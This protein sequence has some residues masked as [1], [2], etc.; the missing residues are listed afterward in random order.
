M[1]IVIYGVFRA[2]L[3]VDTKDRLRDGRVQLVRPIWNGMVRQLQEE[4]Y[5]PEV[6]EGKIY[7]RVK[8]KRK[9]WS[10]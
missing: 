8:R 7:I 10:L 6:K 1:E 9:G 3:K 2:K 4:G 5:E